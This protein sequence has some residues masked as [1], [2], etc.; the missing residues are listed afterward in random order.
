MM[1]LDAIRRSNETLE[2]IRNLNYK[3]K[4]GNNGKKVKAED[5]PKTSKR[6]ESHSY[7]SLGNIPESGY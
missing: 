2:N 3:V 1:F 6:P 5:V 4:L 7:P